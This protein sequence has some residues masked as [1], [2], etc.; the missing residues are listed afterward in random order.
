MIH[1]KNANGTSLI[2]STNH[3]RFLSKTLVLHP[4]LP[5]NTLGITA[6][7]LIVQLHIYSKVCA[8]NLLNG[9]TAVSSLLLQS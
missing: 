9:I 2:M 6:Q 1:I 3:E 7:K 5:R 8:T 4:L